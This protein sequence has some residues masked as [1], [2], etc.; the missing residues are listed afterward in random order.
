MRDPSAEWQIDEHDYP[1]GGSSA[2]K[3]RFLLRYAIL[4]PSGHNTQPWLFRIQAETIEVWA[5]R[6]RSL[7]VVD[8]QDRALVISCG[9]ALG[10]LRVAL[11]HFG[12]EGEMELL[13]DRAEPDLLARVALGQST[14]PNAQDETAFQAIARRRTTRRPF[15][16]VFPQELAAQLQAIAA[17]EGV[18]MA[19]L[20]DAHRKST[21]A[22]LVSEG[23]K[24]QFSDPRFRRELGSWVHSRR[25]A[26]RDGM[27]GSNFGLPDVLSVAGGLVIRTFDMGQ[28]VAAKNQ[29][30]AANSPALIVV[31][32]SGDDEDQ[33]LRAGIAHVRMLLSVAAA[34]LTAAYLNQPI[35]VEELRPQLRAAAGL[36]GMPQL[37][38]R[39]GEGPNVPPAV[40][41]PVEEVL[42]SAD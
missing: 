10:V 21:V 5:D 7:P 17:E 24:A 12:H 33:W 27:S 14:S 25:A 8:P 1:A 36:S 20:T 15:K 35:E 39:V 28:G 42:L 32:T 31:A 30:I 6:R 9:A 19:L 41:R 34:G 40:R 22:V 26:S 4:A 29:Q 16:G 37:L 2:E 18:E 13:P 11:R 38:L 23:D 3:L